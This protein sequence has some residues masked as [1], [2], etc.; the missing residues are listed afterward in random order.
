M[1]VVSNM[2]RDEREFEIIRL[3]IE[4]GGSLRFKDIWESLKGCLLY[5]SDA[6]DE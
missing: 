6:A 5:T 4:R 3:L 2:K 1:Y